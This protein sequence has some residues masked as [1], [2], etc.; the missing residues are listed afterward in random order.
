MVGEDPR[1]SN[2]NDFLD[3]AAKLYRPFGCPERS[4]LKM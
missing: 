4:L 2:R 3:F 1:G